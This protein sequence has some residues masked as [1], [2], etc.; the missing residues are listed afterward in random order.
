MVEEESLYKREKCFTC[1]LLVASNLSCPAIADKIIAASTTD[2]PKHPMTSKDEAYAI[3]PKRDT[4]PYVGFNPTT[5]QKDAGC[6]T[7]PPVSLPK[8]A[9]HCLE[10]TAAA[11]PPDDPPGTRDESQGFVVTYI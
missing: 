8:D 1:L 7:L 3:S 6:L 11:E 2:E 9:T 4:R 10:E 5:P